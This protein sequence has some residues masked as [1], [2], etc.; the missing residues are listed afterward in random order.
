M[1]LPENDGEQ[2]LYTHKKENSKFESGDHLYAIDETF[3][4][5]L[6]QLWLDAQQQPA[7]PE[8][9]YYAIYPESAYYYR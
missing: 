6:Y 3:L 4:R 7:Q 2:Q 5:E 1:D 8:P 9:M